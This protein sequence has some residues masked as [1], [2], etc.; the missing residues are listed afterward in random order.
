[1]NRFRINNKLSENLPALLK[2][3]EFTVFL[4]HGVIKENS[5]RVRNY[6]K[7]HMDL[8]L[9][10]KIIK[11]LSKKGVCISMDQLY[12]YISNNE[13]PPPKSFLLTFDDGFY[14]NLSIAAPVIDD[15]KLSF[16]IYLTTEFV[17]KNKISWTDMLEYCL[18]NT[19][20][21]FVK[22]DNG[23]IF[24]L[25]N[26][27]SKKIFAH[28]IRF[29]VKNNKDIDPYH[30]V[31]KLCSKLKMD[32]IGDLDPQLDRKISWEDIKKYSQKD[33]IIFGGHS[34][35]HKNLNHIS[36]KELAFEINKSIYLLKNKGNL[37]CIHYAYPEGGP[38]SFSER[39]I[40]LL[41]TNNVKTAVTTIPKNN[42]LNTNPYLIGRY[43]IS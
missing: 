42:L 38:D 26:N 39:V 17:D 19:K 40:A 11:E 41:K 4:F 8:D 21:K 18:E 37:D 35:T 7:K 33:F 10:Y 22:L 12:Y 5:Y 15:L 13:S 9:F 27:L 36:E 23:E 6:T 32:K 14:N 43:L 34:H 3:D 31:N 28:K 1:M 30:F 29:M 20:E 25:K 2:E 16:S 24:N